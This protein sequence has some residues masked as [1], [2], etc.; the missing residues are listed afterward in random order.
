MALYQLF[1]G[2]GTLL[3]RY[4]LATVNSEDISL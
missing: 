3:P 1:I 2:Q 4:L